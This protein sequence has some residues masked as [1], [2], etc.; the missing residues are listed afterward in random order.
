VVTALETE[1]VLDA[2]ADVGECPVWDVRSG[3]L[4]WVDIT[5]GRV[6]RFDPDT[7]RDE[8]VEAGEQVGSIAPRADGGL[9]L[10]LERG[11]A[12][13]REW[14]AAIEL[15]AAVGADDPTS[16]MNDGK[17]DAAGRFWAG[18]MA[19][20]ADPEPRHGLY[21]LDAN[22]EV[23]AVLTGVGMSNGIGWSPDGRTM[24]FVDSPTQRVDAFDYD[25]RSGTPSRRRRLVEIP[26]EQGTP[27]G[28]AVDADGCLWVAFW[29]GWCVRRYSDRGV[30]LGVVDVP[31]ERVT[32]CSFGGHGLEDL[33]VTTARSGVLAD[34]LEA[35]PFAG[36]VF[37]I[38]PGVAGSPPRAYGGPK[39]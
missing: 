15:V 6:H 1:L 14:G 3:T 27:D 37:R 24:Y 34:E 8:S 7:G 29:G 32:S 2:R 38:R 18:T 16:R 20:D 13:Q 21:R 35:Q 30:L 36:G 33:Y 4:V 11:F 39:P 5:A 25:L 19:V 10:A 12:V 22:G 26:S 9:V 23:A 31:V 17:C 28:L